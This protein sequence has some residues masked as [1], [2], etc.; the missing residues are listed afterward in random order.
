MHPSKEFGD[1][2]KT[3]VYTDHSAL[4]YLFSKQD[5]KPRLIRWILLLQEFDIEIRDKKGAENLAADHL[6]RLENPELEVLNESAIQDNFPDEYL[7]KIDYKEIPWFADYANYLVCGFLEK[8]LSYQRRKKFFSDIKH[9]FWE[10]P[11]LFKSC[12]DGI[13]RRCVFGDEANAHLLC[14]SCDACQRAGKISKRDEMPQNVI[15]VCEVFD[16]WGIDFM[17]PFPKSHNNLYI[18][19]AIDYVSKWAEAQALPTNDAR[20]VVNFLKRLFARFG[21][22]KALISDRGTH[23]CNNQL[24][25]ILKRYGVTHKISTA[26]HPQTSGQVENTNRALKRI[27]EKTVGSNPKEW[28]IKLEDALWAFRTAYKTPIGTTPF[29]LVY[30]KACHLPVE[31]E[32]KAFWALKTCNLDLHEAGR[33][34]LSQLNELEE[35]R[36]EAYENS[37]I[38]KERTK[39]WHDK[40]IR[41]KTMNVDNFSGYFQIPLDPNDQEKTTFT[42]PYRTFTYRR[43][44]CGLCNAPA[45]FQRCMVAIFHD[46]IEHC[47]EVFMDDFSVFGNTFNSCLSNLD[48]MLTQCEDSNLVLNWEKCHFMVK[49]GIVLGHKIS[50]SGLEVDKAK[51][52]TIAKLPEPTI[53]KAVRSFLGN[54]GFYRRFIKYFSKVTRP[55]TH[56]LRKEVPFVFNEECVKAFNYLK[57]QLTH[58]PIMIAPDWSLPFEIMCDASDFAVGAVLGQRKDKHFHLIYYAN[59]FSGYFQ[60]PIAP[61][62]QEKTTFTC[63]YGTFAYKRMPFGLCNAPATFQRCMMAIFHDMIEECMEVFMDDFSVFGDTFKSC[64]VNLERMLIRCEKSNLVLNWEKCHFMVKEGIVLGHKISKEGIEVDRAKVDVIAKLPHPTNVRGV[65]SFLGHAGFYRRFIKDFS[66]IATPMNKLLEK[67]APFIFSDECIKSFNILKEKLTNAPIMITPN[68]NI[69]F[70]LMCDASDFAMGAVLGQRIEKRFQPIYYASKTLQGAQT[71]YT[72]TEKELLAIV[73]AFDKFRSYLVLAKTVVYTDHSALRYLFSKQD[74]KPRLILSVR[75]VASA[76]IPTHVAPITPHV[77]AV[78]LSPVMETVPVRKLPEGCH[79]VTVPISV[80]PP[81]AQVFEITGN[82][83][84]EEPFPS[85]S[86]LELPSDLCRP[87]SPELDVGQPLKDIMDNVLLSVGYLGKVLGTTSHEKGWF[88]FNKVDG[89]L[90]P[91]LDHP[92]HDWHASFIFINEDSIDNEYSSLKSEKINDIKY[93]EHMLSLTYVSQDWDITQGYACVL[94]GRKTTASHQGTTLV[95][96]PASAKRR[97]TGQN[98]PPFAQQEAGTSSSQQQ[99]MLPNLDTN[100]LSSFLKGPRHSYE[101]FMNFLNVMVCPSL[102]QFFSSLSDADAKKVKAQSII[103]NIASGLNDLQCLSELQSNEI[104]TKKELSTEKEKITKLEQVATSLKRDYDMMKRHYE[105]CNTQR[106]EYSKQVKELSFRENQHLSR[107]EELVK[108][109]SALKE[110]LKA[111]EDNERRIIAGIPALV[112]RIFNYQALSHRIR[113][114]VRLAKSAE[115][116]NIFNF[117][118]RKLPELPNPL[119][120]VITS[121][122]NENAITEVDVAGASIENMRFSDLENLCKNPDVTIDD[123]LNYTPQNE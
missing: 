117:M 22:P 10:D 54:A 30:G 101:D 92:A 123:V 31:I 115:R 62:D 68:W 15:Q 2:S 122:I 87:L 86:H 84:D 77:L 50:K 39:K 63:P 81:M 53:A 5:A 59:G 24:E 88:T 82:I 67:D 52:E 11:H 73:F 8:G 57:E 61:E 21:T 111:K 78:S 71:N 43:V 17:G 91:A 97:R 60:I 105:N 96:L 75:S 55:I 120:E 118:K 40:R 98:A 107:I 44:P 49:E 29:R 119:P 95:T 108:E 35:L 51:I 3:V 104:T 28:S 58:A 80:E 42:C 83:P 72:T 27:L 93:G 90:R 25:K 48:K 45:T 79:L 14:K 12:P 89:F 38:Y 100:I 18:L 9:Y 113:E 56:L 121:K 103:L 16:I 99:I 6:S 20:V 112:N 19:V 7:L 4:R 102:V 13:I 47:M 65:R 69:P 109:N 110:Q 33:L 66:K 41:K 114:F 26:Y 94:A 70:E 32:H 37:L 34:R 23:F 106:A 76:A 46:M 64:L 116:L 85:L 36:H 1:N 74:A